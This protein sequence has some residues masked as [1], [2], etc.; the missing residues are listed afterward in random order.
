MLPRITLFLAVLVFGSS[1]IRAGCSSVSA[2]IGKGEIA[3]AITRGLD[4]E[5][6]PTLQLTNDQIEIPGSPKARVMHPE[7][8]LVTIKRS[9]AHHYFWAR[10]RCHPDVD[11]MP[12]I[13]LL[14][15]SPATGETIRQSLARSSRT[16][17]EVSV[18]AG[19]YIHMQLKRGDVVISMRVRCLARTRVGGDVRLYD[20]E[21]RRIYLGR[22][23]APDVAE[24]SY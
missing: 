18:P 21:T 1:A 3:S 11:C 9:P 22:L 14:R 10:L 4:R 23:T 24:A 7:L 17:K 5:G 15:V 12:F 6:F 8:V 13:A 19:T 2:P 16:S 20:V